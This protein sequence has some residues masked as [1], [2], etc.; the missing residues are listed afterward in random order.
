MLLR[1]EI[2]V[3]SVDELIS[4]LEPV[5]PGEISSDIRANVRAELKR[6]KRNISLILGFTSTVY[7]LACSGEPDLERAI[8]QV[9]QECLAINA[10]VSRILILQALRA[11]TWIDYSDRVREQYAE[12]AEATRALF[13]LTSPLRAQD[14]ASAL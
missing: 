6:I 11:D 5:E 7:P 2:Q 14:L 12:M 9:R 1:R 4:R 10:T 8:M 3:S 13:A